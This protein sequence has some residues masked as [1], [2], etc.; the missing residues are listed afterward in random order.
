MTTGRTLHL[1]SNNL[2]ADQARK[3]KARH[4]Q[5]RN[6]KNHIKLCAPRTNKNKQTKKTSRRTAAESLPLAQT[7]NPTW[8]Y[9]MIVVTP[10]SVKRFYSST[11]VLLPIGTNP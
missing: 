4:M 7:N 3:Y 5:Q 10:P 11:R 1:L 8:A 6:T 9:T 2:H